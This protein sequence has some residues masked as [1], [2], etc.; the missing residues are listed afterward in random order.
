MIGVTSSC[1]VFVS[2]A[3][4]DAEYAAKIKEALLSTDSLTKYDVF[5]S[6]DNTSLASGSDYVEEIR[7]ALNHAYCYLLLL[8]PAF[9]DSQ[10]CLAEL[11]AAWGQPGVHP[12]RIFALLTPGTRADILNGTPLEHLQTVKVEDAV[13]WCNQV[14]S[15]LRKEVPEIHDFELVGP[16][17]NDLFVDPKQKLISVQ[18]LS[19]DVPLSAEYSGEKMTGD[20]AKRN[21]KQILI[22]NGGT[23]LSVA[24][25]G[26]ARAG[27][28]F[29][30]AK[31]SSNYSKIIQ[32]TQKIWHAR[33]TISSS[34]IRNLSKHNVSDIALMVGYY[35]STAHVN[36]DYLIMPV[37]DFLEMIHAIQQH[38]SDMNDCQLDLEKSGDNSI[39]EC[40][41]LVK[42]D[43][44]QYLNRFAVI[45]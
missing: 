14:F 19:N 35:E 23:E 41:G 31:Y 15:Y 38:D 45:S 37:P 40:S 44:N 1:L 25:Y 30:E 28:L 42:R 34:L 29:M 26:I 20:A 24:R 3:K 18:Q 4:K 5:C 33:F 22:D 10:F 13:S 2:H 39:T 9:M 43:F 8:S 7:Q 6:E 32:S 16:K 11:G 36:Y 12:H 17:V 21:L 27:K